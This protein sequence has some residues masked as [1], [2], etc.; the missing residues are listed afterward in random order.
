MLF[1]TWIYAFFLALTC[2]L[3]W[4]LPGG[5]LRQ[6]LLIAAGMTFYAY[7]YPPHLWVILGFTI[8][9]FGI[10][11]VA[12]GRPPAERRAVLA[13]AAALCVGLLAYCKYQGF[14]RD[15]VAALGWTDAAALLAGDVRVP[16][17][18]SFFTFEYVHYLIE[19]RRG[20]IARARGA[21]LFLFI[22][23]FPTLI[24]GP[25]KRFGDFQPQIAHAGFDADAVAAGLGRIVAGLAKKIVVADTVAR[26]IAPIWADPAAHG[27]TALWL[28]TYGY[29]LQI[30]CDF[31]G[32]SDIAIGSAQLL[33]F[34][35]PENFD[36]PYLKTNIAAFWRSWHMS[37][38]SWITDY[39]YIPLGG[40]RFGELRGHGNRLIAMTLCG[41]WHGAAWHFAFW[42]LYHGVG[43]SAYRAYQQTRRRVQPGWSPSQ[44]PLMRGLATAAT[45]HF[46]CIGWVLFVTDF[47]TARQVI[48][49]LFGIGA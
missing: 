4:S 32:Y 25:I 14:L 22:M 10:T 2:L 34:H 19:L 23:F 13:G 21:D 11:V 45:F 38:T 17:A 15:S 26:W 44:H 39:V 12:D 49:R 18:V 30:Y 1:N 29:A 6:W 40:N 5:A 16:L 7:F 33:G 28:G 37:L 42:G 20:T 24:C 46:V 9:V 43:L 8:L 31:A 35:V 36:R 48:P 47:A 3:T 27:T 41:L